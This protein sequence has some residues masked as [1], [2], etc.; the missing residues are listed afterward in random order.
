MSQPNKAVVRPRQPLTDRQREIL[1][2]IESMWTDYGPPTV[3]DLTTASGCTGLQ[4]TVGH[5][6]ALARKGWLELREPKAGHATHRDRSGIL[7]LV[8]AETWPWW[9]VTLRGLDASYRATI[10][11]PTFS[12]AAV[13]AREDWHAIGAPD[14]LEGIEI[15][16][17][18]RTEPEFQGWQ[19]VANEDAE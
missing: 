7:R 9:S 13:W 6:Q 3:R 18:P 4:S 15:G 19:E 11:A 10:Q 12:L 14:T 1:N 8:R 5:L 17:S 2:L 16:L